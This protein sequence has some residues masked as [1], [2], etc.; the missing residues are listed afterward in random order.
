MTDAGKRLFLEPLAPARHRAAEVSER[1]A[2]EIASGRLAPGDRLPP[3]HELMAA[4]GVSRSVVREAV[5]A[6]RA[7]G[8]VVTRQ[9]AGAFV[10]SDPSRVPFRLDPR[11]FASPKGVADILELRLAVEV[12]ASA[13]AAERATAAGIKSIERTLKMVDR[14]IAEDEAAIEQDAAFHRAIAIATGN[15]IY[16]AFLAFLG[17]QLIPRQH[18]GAEMAA[19]PARRAYLEKIQREHR[20]IAQAIGQRDIN[21]ARRAMRAHLANGLAHYRQHTAQSRASAAIPGVRVL[22]TE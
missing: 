12:E 14:A 7:E 11:R 19:G 22:E 16:D 6:L 8:L 17:R 15:P 9:G 10:A 4:M 3:E 21:L 1:I 18:L 5:A 20:L 13:L 2:A